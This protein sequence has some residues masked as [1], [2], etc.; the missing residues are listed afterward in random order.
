MIRE[1]AESVSAE[2]LAAGRTEITVAGAFASAPY[3]KTVIAPVYA[4]GADIALTRNA[5]APAARE[6]D[7]IRLTYTA[8]NTGAETL[9]DVTVSDAA[10]GFVS[11]KFS[12]SPGESRSFTHFWTADGPLGLNAAARYS[13]ADERFPLIARAAAQDVVIA[14]DGV[15]LHLVG[16]VPEVPY[17]DRARLEI[18]I[19]NEGPFDYEYLTLT[20]PMLGQIPFVPGSLRAGETASVQIDTPPLVQNV[21]YSFS[22]TMRDGGGTVVTARSG[23]VPV[24]VAPR[25]SA[26]VRISAS[27]SENHGG[28]DKAAFRLTLSGGAEMR[29]NVVIGEK[30]LGPLRTLS[31]V[32]SARETVVFLTVPRTAD[33]CYRFYASDGAGEIAEAEPV[34]AEIVQ[35]DGNG[36][37]SVKNAVYFILDRARGSVWILLS[38][39]A[40]IACG[41]I[42]LTV[43]RRKMT[44]AASGKN[45]KERN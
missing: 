3:A 15:F 36:R 7:R 5:S 8:R 17:G 40:L 43:R 12:L 16:G 24:T 31:V 28:E 10:A 25:E 37:F 21:E 44:R 35:S 20:E 45:V 4:S 19:V 6:G 32:P 30:S 13:R 14:G 22:L 18:E 9:A 11:E 42:L 39:A 41:A 34:F 23:P 38:V 27:A 29:K 26:P 2:A 1:F 33:G